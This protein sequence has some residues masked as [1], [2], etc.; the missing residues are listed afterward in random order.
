MSH[1]KNEDLIRILWECATIC[2]H[3]NMACLEEKDLQKLVMCIRLNMDCAEICRSTAV[4]LSRGS[5]HMQHLMQECIEV[6][7]ACAD[8]CEKHSHM[9]HCKECADACRQC[10]EACRSHSHVD[11]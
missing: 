11:A 6:C 3:C 7:E 4:L 8:E 2:E 10:A 5:D 1:E 9:Q